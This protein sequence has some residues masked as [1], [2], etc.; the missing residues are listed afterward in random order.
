M[1]DR[2]NVIR[3][4]RN[5]TAECPS[6]ENIG[7][8]VRRE[9][10]S[11]PYGVG[12]DQVLLKVELPVAYCSVCDLEF[13]DQE[14]ELIKHDAVCRHLGLMTPSDVKDVREMNQMTKVDFSR[15]TGLGE[16]SLSRWE[17]GTTIQN[18]G[19][20]N[21]LY[22]LRNPENVSTLLARSEG[23]SVCENKFQLIEI[24]PD[25]RKAQYAFQL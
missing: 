15:V 17:R 9:Q 16:A 10:Q 19:I 20:D 13:I 8:E 22:L 25:M 5:T 4:E 21:F 23:E 6:C 14:G 11:F 12:E 18:A 3:L 24:T 7:A 1:N 2:N